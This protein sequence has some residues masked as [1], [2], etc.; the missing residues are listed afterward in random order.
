[1]TIAALELNDQALLLQAEDGALHAE[2][3]Y[4]CLTENG[5]VTGE[6]ARAMA[7]REPQHVYDQHWRHLNQVSLPVKH[8][9]ARHHADIAFAQLSKCWQSAGS[10]EDL[11]VLVPGSIARERLSLLLGMI[12]ALPSRVSLVI[13]SALPACADSGQDTLY[14]DVQMHELVL[15]VCR[16]RRGTIVIEDQEVFPGLGMAQIQNALALHVSN[17]L[18]ESYRF[19]PRHSSETE[20]AIFD[21]IPH[22]LIRLRWDRNVSTRLVTPNGEYPCILDRDA[23]RAVLAE[24]FSSVHSFIAKWRRYTP[25]LSQSSAALAGLADKFAGAEIVAQTTATQYCLARHAE[26][27]EQVDE[28]H[29]VR[30]L[31]HG[32]THAAEHNGGNA[33]LATHLLCGDLA[34]P[35]SRP[36]S[37]RIAH[38]GPRVSGEW[39]DGAALTVVM[40]NN[41]VL[42]ALQRAAEV[43]LPPSCT[44]GESIHVGGHELRLIRVDNG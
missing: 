41:R 32:E 44:P 35:L 30:S 33:R 43:R 6:E 22:W 13:D 17:Q 26:I 23:V 2:P 5:I 16:N 40:N 8:K 36:V 27:R 14:L 4:A 12:E 39:D 42:E 15:T 10:P 7:W 9:H 1:M 37:I 34:V 11:I 24:R 25:L 3:G 31:K 21:R 20:Q 18:I 29:R 28:L 38:D 19:D